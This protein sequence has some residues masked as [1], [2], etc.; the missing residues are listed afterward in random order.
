MYRNR[1]EVNDK[2]RRGQNSNAYLST[3]QP[4]GKEPWLWNQN[5]IT[6]LVESSTGCNSLGQVT[7]ISEPQAAHM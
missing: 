1:F 7:L 2:S 6:V 4:Q 5:S 3:F